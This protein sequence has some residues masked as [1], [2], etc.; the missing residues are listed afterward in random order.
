M[1]IHVSSAWL[2]AL[3][4]VVVTLATVYLAWYLLRGRRAGGAVVRG[5]HPLVCP[6]CRRAYPAGA[7][8]CPIDAARLQP[9][10]EGAAGMPPGRGGKCPR[11]RRAF[12]V[13]MRFCPMDAEELVPLQSWAAMGGEGSASASNVHAEAFADHLVVGTAKICPVCASKYDLSAG[14]C[15]RDASELVT[16]N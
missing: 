10:I 5:H 3:A 4:L 8:Y 13:G 6:T 1:G 11:C 16:V 7:H 9:N 15:G 2:L 12:E 14:Y